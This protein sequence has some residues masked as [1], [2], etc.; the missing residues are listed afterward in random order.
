MN[1]INS[2]TLILGNA[3]YTANDDEKGK[4]RANWPSLNTTPIDTV[5]LRQF[6]HFRK[7]LT[8]KLIDPRRCINRENFFLQKINKRPDCGPLF[9]R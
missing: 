9:G 5:W 1:I 6:Q 7:Q 2:T 3:M 4:K 8:T